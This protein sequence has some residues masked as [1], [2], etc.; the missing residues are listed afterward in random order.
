MSDS[1]PFLDAAGIRR[2]QP[3][4]P[5]RHPVDAG[6]LAFLGILAE[7][8]EPGS[9]QRQ[10]WD[11]L[12]QVHGFQAVVQASA[13]CFHLVNGGGK[14]RNEQAQAILDGKLPSGQA[15]QHHGSYRRRS[16]VA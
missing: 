4:L 9:V 10:G 6:S 13:R 2:D 11:I 3:I 8:G 16:Q 1:T 7:L 14:V 5:Q 12:L 15:V